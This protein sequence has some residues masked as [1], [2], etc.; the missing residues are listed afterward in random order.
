[1]AMFASLDEEVGSS[2]AKS[3]LA[4]RLRQMTPM[5]LEVDNEDSKAMVV[6]AASSLTGE[7]RKM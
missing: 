5:E 1:M 6:D 3:T 4:H 2:Q 7:K